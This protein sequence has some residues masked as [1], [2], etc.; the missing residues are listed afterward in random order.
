MKL[1]QINSVLNYGSTGKIVEQIALTAQSH[2]WESVV[3]HGV[4]YSRAS[5]Q[6]EFIV[7]SGWQTLCHE[8][9]SL[10]FDRH[11]LSSAKATKRLTEQIRE[12]QPDV[13]HLHNIHNYY[14]NY[15]VLFEYLV[16]VEIPVVWTLHDCWPFTGHCSYFDMVG[17]EKWKTGCGK[18]PGL[19][20]YPRSL[21]VDRSAK[22][23]KLKQQLFS[24]VSERL[25]IVPVSHWLEV[26]VR[27][28][29]MKD[30]SVLTIH[31]GI[32]TEAFS[33][34]G[35][36]SLRERMKIE[37][38]FVVLGVALPWTPRKGL[39]DMFS[40]AEMLPQDKF[41]VVTVGLSD[42]QI[43]QCPKNIIGVKKTSSVAEL[44]EYYS[45]ASVFVN[46]TYEDNY[47]TTNLE[48]MACGTPVI[49]YRTGGSPEAVTP[50][51]G[52]VVEQGDVEGIASIVKS[53]ELRDKSEV[54][55]QRK[56][57]RAR[58]EQEFDKDKCFERYIELY[59]SLLQ[60][61]KATLPSCGHEDE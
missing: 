19:G 30:A 52:W 14:I 61:N 7:G 37:A 10:L 57:C 51:T 16:S 45:L 23:Y 32:N 4:K 58:A 54:L 13:I 47:P 26:F 31:N 27:E 5:T 43:Q 12:Y 6:K 49:T 9:T 50:E 35:A 29:F 44:A 38:K 36:A 53:L 46:P 39:A 17:C 59:E 11:G 22:N 60:C 25:T 40:L 3:A 15:K 28:S 18:C 33:P 56:A 8:A 42:K 34:K 2:G 41:Q 24:A 1:F 20:V 55:A 48:A 21:F